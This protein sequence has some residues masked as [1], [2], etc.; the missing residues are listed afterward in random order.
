MN[1]VFLLGTVRSEPQRMESK[2]GSVQVALD[3]ETLE[4]DRDERSGESYVRKQS[5]RLIF[6]GKLAAGIHALATPGRELS[7]EGKLCYWKAGAV[8]RVTTARGTETSVTNS[9]QKVLS[10]THQADLA[11]LNAPAISRVASRG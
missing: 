4:D 8:I 7:I 2:N 6:S 3:F 9:T 1:R 5:H 10:S 11:F